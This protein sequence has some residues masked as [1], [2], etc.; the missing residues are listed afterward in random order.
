LREI[1][2]ILILTLG[3]SSMSHSVRAS[4]PQSENDYFHNS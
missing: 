3:D 2:Y 4:F 1:S